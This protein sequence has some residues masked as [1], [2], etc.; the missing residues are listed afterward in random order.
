MPAG[1]VPR[2]CFLVH[3]VLSLGALINTER[4]ALTRPSGICDAFGDH[5]VAGGAAWQRIGAHPVAARPFKGPQR[6]A[7]A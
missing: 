5:D 6:V 4:F 3:G 1:N 2:S 7:T